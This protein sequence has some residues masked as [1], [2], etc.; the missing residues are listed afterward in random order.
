MRL[1]PG[2]RVPF[3]RTAITVAVVVGGLIAAG[4]ITGVVV[5]WLWFA[6]IGY[7]DVFWTVVSS[8]ALLFT[9]VLV[10]SASVIAASGF[11]AHLYARRPGSWQVETARLSG[12]PEFISELADQLAPRI[13]WRASIAGSAIALGLMLATGEI[14]NWDLVLRFLHQVP[15]GERDPVFG[16]DISFYLF[17]LPTYIAFKNWLLQV[18]FCSAIVAGAVYGVR[19]DI[20]FERPPRGLSAAATAHGS[21]LLGMFFVL[22][23]G[24]YALDR[25][26]LLYGDNGVVVGAGYTDLHVELPVLWVLIV[27]AIAA[28]VASWINMRRRD[29][30]IPAASVLLVFGTSFVFALIYPALFQRLYVK[31]SELQLEMPYIKHN[32]ALTR[33][34]YGL[35]QIAVKPFPAEQEL[36]LTSLAANR[37][38]ID[39]IRLWDVQPLMDTYA[40]LQ[41][42]RTYYKFLSVDIDRYRLD[43]GYR[44]VMLSARELAPS[45]LPANAQTWVN[46]HLLFTHGNGVVMSPVTEKST[47]GLPSFYLQDIPPVTHGGPAIREPRLYFGEGGEGDEGY[48]IVKGS[49]AEFDYPKGK[50]N[51]YTTYSGR[52]GIAIDSTA[53]RSLFAWQFDDP[54]ILLTDY[55]TNTSRILLHRNVQDRVRTIAPFLSLDHDPYLVVSNGRLFWM[56]DAYTTSRWFPYAQ[57]G[58]GDGANYIRNAVK[59]VIDAYNGTVDFY[60]SDPADPILRTYQ[61]IFPGLFKP[62]A[63]MPQDLQQHIRYPEDLFQIQAQLYRAYHMDAAEVFYNREDLWQFPRELIG[64]DGG[65][66]PGTPM[67]PYYMIMRLPEEPHEEFVLILPMV[68]SQ[69]DNMIAWLAARCDP[70]NYGKLIVY[71]FPKDKLVYGPFQIEARIQQN[72]EISQQ[73][74][75]WNQM[76]SRV[77]RGHLLV[78]PIENSILYVSPLYLRAESGQL[79]ELKRVIAAYGD[80]VVMEATLGEALAALF[81]ESAPLASP[82]QGT[83]DAR[84]R[85]A[86]AHYNRAIERLKAGDWSGFGAELDALRPLLE[87]L[88]G[89]RSQGQK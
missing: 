14:S 13:P 16:Q 53:R 36:N 27:L 62:L 89:G 51:V 70:P 1:Q 78:V 58:F 33:M 73:I 82:P 47:E 65:N 57:P 66:S 68:P 45:M 20:T 38:T 86:L 84:A 34:A 81:K 87:A 24:S 41:E 77:I 88:G 42:I 5:D 12:T 67:T 54:N 61:R 46:L 75:L 21:A 3:R 52:D 25:F 40:Q 37:A 19:G 18:L 17:S 48:V 2:S 80:R 32:I 4:R 26:L 15:Y 55:I 8:K 22:K 43:A 49:V 69:R 74:S 72:T 31:P 23:A 56:Q 9:A 29:Y 63:A 60:I 59:V 11:L 79:P 35:T 28:A 30:R 76:G 6:S 39:N 7:V 64:I 50:D 83:A 10:A 85:D 71:A 44:Q